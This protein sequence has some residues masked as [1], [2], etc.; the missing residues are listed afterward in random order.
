MKRFLL[1]AVVTFLAFAALDKA[2]FYGG[3]WQTRVTPT[4]NVEVTMASGEVLRGTLSREWDGR[5][6]V[7]SDDGTRTTDV[8][9]YRSMTFSPLSIERS[10]ALDSQWRYWLP[11]ALI[12]LFYIAFLILWIS[13]DAR[14][15]R[16]RFSRSAG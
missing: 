4:P 6:V 10:T 1:F 15:N 3:I 7:L 2:L 11:S 14:S 13:F 8:E 9:K 5:F 12:L 16:L